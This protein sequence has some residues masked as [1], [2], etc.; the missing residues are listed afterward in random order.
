MWGDE[1]RPPERVTLEWRPGGSAV[2]SIRQ[3]EWSVERSGRKMLRCSGHLEIDQGGLSGVGAL[4]GWGSRTLQS[5]V[6]TLDFVL[7]E[8]GALEDSCRGFGAPCL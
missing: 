5:I 3:R 2:A 4:R 8:G 1:G 6:K 7:S